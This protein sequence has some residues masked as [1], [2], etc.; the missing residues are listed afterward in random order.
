MPPET[1]IFLNGCIA[2]LLSRYLLMSVDLSCSQLWPEDIL[3]SV[4][5]AEI[6]LSENC[7]E[8]KR[9]GT[10]MPAGECSFEY[11]MAVAHMNSKRLGLPAVTCTRSNQVKIPG[12]GGGAGEAPPLSKELLAVDGCC[13]RESL[14]SEREVATHQ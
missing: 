6:Q 4:V 7:E 11:D 10:R 12:G 13:R 5:K 8:G 1:L 3:I 9:P 14:F 2:R